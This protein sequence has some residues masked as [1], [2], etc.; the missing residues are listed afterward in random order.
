MNT[1]EALFVNLK[2]LAQ[3][4]PYQ[5]LN[6]RQTLFQVTPVD[7]NNRFTEYFTHMPEWLRRWLEGSTR[8]SDFNRIRDLIYKAFKIMEREKER[9]KIINHLKEAMQGLNNL[10]K[11]YETDLTYMA[12]ITTLIDDIKEQVG[13]YVNEVL[14]DDNSDFFEQ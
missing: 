2:V 12:R 7:T 13:Q 1:D 9:Q 11:T 10:K 8:D 14:D 6:T 3:L 5:R 4:Q